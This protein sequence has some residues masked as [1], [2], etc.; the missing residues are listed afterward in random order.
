MLA[1]VVFC[2]VIDPAIASYDHSIVI[3]NRFRFMIQTT[4][5]VP[6]SK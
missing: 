5:Q 1:S 3:H 6:S 4:G 2:V